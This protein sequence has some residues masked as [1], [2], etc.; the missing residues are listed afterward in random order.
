MSPTKIPAG[1]GKIA[2]RFLQCIVDP[3]SLLL[4]TDTQGLATCALQYI[5]CNCTVHHARLI[6][7]NLRYVHVMNSIHLLVRM[8]EA[9]TACMRSSLY[10]QLSHLQLLYGKQETIRAWQIALCTS[11]TL[12][13]KLE[14]NIPR[15]EPARS[16]SQF[17]H[18]CIC[19]RFIYYHVRFGPTILMQQNR[20]TD[21]GNI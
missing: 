20:W 21:R 8:A 3:C 14:T 6:L 13:Q 7:C 16:R 17:P 15:N 9:I 12:C 11:N 18:S 19:E 5:Q 10:V 1:D 2:N 4:F